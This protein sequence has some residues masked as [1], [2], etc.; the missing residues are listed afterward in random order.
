MYLAC[1]IETT[2]FNWQTD[3]I[4]GISFYD[5]QSAYYLPYRHKDFYRSY[6]DDRLKI[7][8]L[9][10]NNKEYNYKNETNLYR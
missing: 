1:D 10:Y 2:G 4:T 7:Q 9:L 3:K 8:N 6:R 5:G